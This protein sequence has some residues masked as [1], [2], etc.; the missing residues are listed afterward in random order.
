[1]LRV[2]FQLISSVQANPCPFHWAHC[3]FMLSME[4]RLKLTS[5]VWLAGTIWYCF[6][7]SQLCFLISLLFPGNSLLDINIGQF[8]FPLWY[9]GLVGRYCTRLLWES[10]AIINR[11][12]FS[13]VNFPRI[14]LEQKSKGMI[15]ILSTEEKHSTCHWN[16]SLSLPFQYI[17]AYIHKNR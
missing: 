3:L 12:V 7:A 13:Q 14:Y 4:S 16:M 15:A 10:L 8:P 2:R 17:H 5:A 1:M 11:V 9:W 6:L